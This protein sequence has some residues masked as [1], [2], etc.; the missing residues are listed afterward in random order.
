MKVPG[1]RLLAKSAACFVKSCRLVV[2]FGALFMFN[3][4]G[5]YAGEQILRVSLNTELQ[6]TRS[7][8]LDR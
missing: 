6:I 1:F 5:V 7:D 4:S 3:L 8:R 2:L